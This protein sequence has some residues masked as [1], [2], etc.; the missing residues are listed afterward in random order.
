VIK[1]LAGVYAEKE[2]NLYKDVSSHSIFEK[3]LGVLLR[4]NW[5]HPLAYFRDSYIRKI[6]YVVISTL[7][8]KHH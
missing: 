5:N 7:P 3:K 1:E 2:S 6:N 4:R 8:I